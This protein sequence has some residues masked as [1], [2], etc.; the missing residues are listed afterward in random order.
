V[1][2]LL[3]LVLPAYGQQTY[4]PRYDAYVGYAFLDIPQLGLFEN[5]VATQVGF[6]PKTWMSFG[7]DYTFAEGDGTVTP[8]LLPT[9]LQQQLGAQLGQLAALGLL[10]PG[11][12]LIVP[13][14]SRTQTFAVGPQL[15]YRHLTHVTLFLRPVFAGAIHEYATPEPR[16]P[17][18][19]QVVKGL[20]PAGYKTDTAPFV[21]FGGGFD[22]LVTKHFAI[23]TQADLV[24]DHLFNDILKNGQWTTRFSIGPAF[25]FGRNIVK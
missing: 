22:I 15:A 6:R 24:Y 8:N 16:D 1:L 25:N 5:G 12:Q 14:H 23:R 11:Y 3:L 18:A 21:G 2:P 13:I 10:P 4:V 20:T 7:F 19:A 17:I 9:S